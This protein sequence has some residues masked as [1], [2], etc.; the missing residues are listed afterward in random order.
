MPQ[1]HMAGVPTGKADGSRNTG[2][3]RISTRTSPTVY[4]IA[5]AVNTWGHQWE[6]KKV[7]F[8]CDN[9]AV[10]AIWHKGLTKQPEAMDLVRML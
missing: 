8:H 5:A 10:R 4:A 3:L 7:L 1:V 9:E 6:C 2:Q